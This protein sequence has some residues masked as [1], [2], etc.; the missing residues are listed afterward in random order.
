MNGVLLLLFEKGY[1]F[2]WKWSLNLAK[3]H[4]NQSTA[5]AVFDKDCYMNSKTDEIKNYRCI[6]A[7]G[8]G[9][10]L[11]T[12]ILKLPFLENSNKIILIDGHAR[13]TT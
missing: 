13:F 1:F 5:T 8:G 12:M 3:F 2:R 10:S 6:E 4:L 11:P 7:I 9:I